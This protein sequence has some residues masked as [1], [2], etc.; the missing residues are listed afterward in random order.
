M[1]LNPALPI[2]MR[3]TFEAMHV[4]GPYRTQVCRVVKQVSVENDQQKYQ[5]LSDIED[6]SSGAH[7]SSVF[8]RL[9]RSMGW[10]RDAA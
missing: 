6:L 8:S 2:T 1:D 3:V 7:V 9:K 5:G 10:A 4:P